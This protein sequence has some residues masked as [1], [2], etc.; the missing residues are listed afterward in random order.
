[1]NR[2]SLL[3]HFD[4][5]AE[6]PGAVAKLRSLVLDLAVRGRLVPQATKPSQDPAWDQFREERQGSTPGNAAEGPLFCTP[7]SW[8]WASL[9]E[10][11]GP[12]GQKKPDARFTYVDVGAIDNERGVIKPELEVLAAE[13]A[14]SR[15]RKLVT[16]NSV[17][18]STVRPYLRNIAVIDRKFSPPAIV[19]TAFA[20]LQPKPFLDSR[21][22]FHWLR[23]QPFQEQVEARMKGVAYPAISDSEFWQCPIPLPPNGGAAAHRGEGGGV[24]GVVR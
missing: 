21:Y 5:L 16:P 20:V 12:C 3:Q 4:A 14:P 7:D 11:A 23:S 1:M 9:E 17:I 18:Y 24:A 13:D 2:T 10:V 15:A 19:S 8:C 22:L 6:M